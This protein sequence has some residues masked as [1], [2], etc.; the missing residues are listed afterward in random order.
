MNLYQIRQQINTELAQPQPDEARISELIAERD[1]LAAAENANRSDI[2]AA[3]FDA[4]ML[5]ALHA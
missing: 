2:D 5:D 4:R 1:R 3:D